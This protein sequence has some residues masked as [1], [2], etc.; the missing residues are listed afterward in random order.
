MAHARRSA[1]GRGKSDAK[2]VARVALRE[3]DLPKACLDGPADAKVVA[4]HRRLL[5]RQRTAAARA[6]RPGQ[7]VGAAEQQLQNIAAEG[8]QEVY[9]KNR[10]RRATALQVELIDIDYIELDF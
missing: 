7:A 3:P 1:R 9:F 4:D 5:A 8:L 2:T 6:G 10:G